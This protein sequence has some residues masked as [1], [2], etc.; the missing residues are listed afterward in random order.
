MTLL[1]CRNGQRVYEGDC[2]TSHDFSAVQ[3]NVIERRAVF[4]SCQ[5][6]APN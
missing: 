6:S 5:A 3:L 2:H 4:F 1:H